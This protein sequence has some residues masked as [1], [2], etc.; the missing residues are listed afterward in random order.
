MSSNMVCHRDLKPNNIIVTDID[1]I[2]KISDFNV[3]KICDHYNKEQNM[4]IMTKSGS[5]A[6]CAPEIFINGSYDETIE[7]WSAGLV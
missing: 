4:K 1:N 5:V 6:Y 7:V 2:I 3:S